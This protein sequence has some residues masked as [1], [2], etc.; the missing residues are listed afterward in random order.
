M[1]RPVPA[2]LLEIAEALVPDAPPGSARLAEHGNMHHVVLFPGVAAVR[3]TR[4]PDAAAEL[5]RRVGILRAV[6]AAGLP[7]AVPEPLTAVTTFGERAAVAVSWIDGA[8]LPEG[9]GDP[10]AFGPLL[11][12]LREVEVSPELQAVLHRPRRYAGGS[13]WADILT[14]EVVPRLP[15]KWRDAVRQRL[16]TLL[17]LEEVPARLV[18]GDLGGGNV[19]FGEDGKPAGVLDWD[20]AILSDPAIDAALVAT[21]HG[22]DVLGA[23]DEE[24]RRRARIWNDAVGVEHLHAVFTGRPLSH[25]EG[26]VRAVVAW[27][28]ERG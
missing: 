17:A 21:W 3:I 22:W 4:R 15:A 24:T 23:T 14:G 25:V 1:S 16:D 7:F 12:A 6:A 8:G 27:L 28:E 10:A 26:F 5:P 11:E 9:A 13:G 18:H 20:L 2:D 19:H